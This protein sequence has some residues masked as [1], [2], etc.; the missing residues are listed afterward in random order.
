MDPEREGDSCQDIT[1]HHS[2]LPASMGSYSLSDSLSMAN[3][4]KSHSELLIP[5]K[6]LT[7]PITQMDSRFHW[8]NTEKPD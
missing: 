5:S 2:L 7:R 3:A 8:D 4:A 6:L 1:M